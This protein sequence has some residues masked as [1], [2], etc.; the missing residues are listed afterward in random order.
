MRGSRPTLWIAFLAAVL[1][2]L[3]VLAVYSFPAL[4]QKP[5]LPL[6][7]TLTYKN[8]TYDYEVI[9]IPS[10][11]TGWGGP[12]TNVTFEG[13]HFRLWPEG[14][15]SSTIWLQGTAV[16]AGGVDL[17]FGSFAD[18]Q[19]A[20]FNP[21][22]SVD[23]WFSPDGAF[24]VT[25]I[26]YNGGSIEVRLYASNPPVTDAAETVPLDVIKYLPNGTTSPIRIDFGSVTLLIQVDP[27]LSAA[28]IHLN[29]SATLP[30]STVESFSAW[31]GGSTRPWCG[32]V[33]GSPHDILAGATCAETFAPDHS[34]GMVWDSDLNITLLV[35]Q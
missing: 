21:W 10:Y 32:I 2:A 34:V 22:P 6:G 19:S 26:G 13:V 9:T 24:G 27:L 28:F 12:I 29:V 16:G 5:S 3:S 17:A 7:G 35:R 14:N 30:N 8:I 20:A 4:T 15:S 11:G 1:A 25:M 18:N 33:W 31:Q 23:S